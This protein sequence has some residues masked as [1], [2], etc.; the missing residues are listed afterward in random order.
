MAPK[1]S[2]DNIS[3][4]EI[5]EGEVPT[6]LNLPKGCAFCSRCKY[7]QAR[8]REEVP[9]LREIEPGHQVACFLAEK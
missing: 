1:L 7:A 9:P 2:G 6:V 3:K 5:P 8:C 4:Y